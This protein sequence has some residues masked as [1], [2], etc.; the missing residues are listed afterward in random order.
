[1]VPDELGR[2]PGAHNVAVDLLD[3]D[4][5]DVF[6]DRPYAGNPLAVVH[7]TDGL[8]TAQ[9]QAL[10]R[11]FNLA[12]TTFPVVRPD[13]SAYDVR[14]FTTAEE[15]PF[16][17]H[18]TL[19]TAWLLRRQK[20]LDRDDVVQHCGAGEVPVRVEVDGAELTA[21]PRYVHRRD[22]AAA[23]ASAIGVGSSDVD[24]PAYEASAGLGWVFLR[25]RP[26]AVE[27]ARTPTSGWSVPPAGADLVGGVCVWSSAAGDPLTVHA[28]VFCPDVGVT[29]DPATGSAAA[30]LGPVLVADGLAGR[31]GET[32]YRIAQGAEIGR[33]ST[34][35]GRVDADAG[36][37][38]RVLVRGGVTHVATGRIAV[39]PA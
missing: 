15:L 28:R 18:P 6:T 29:E 34:L 21:R 19:G 37:A 10:A 36:T 9:L 1:V 17:G 22:D 27:R 16:A 12:E 5:V 33:P 20:Q 8:A 35:N 2:R 23:L 31:D 25:V 13:G 38:V 14:I 7:G 39:P 26:D 11:E 3:Y 24:G 30:A 4:V 32:A